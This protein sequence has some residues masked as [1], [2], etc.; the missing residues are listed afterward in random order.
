M[1]VGKRICETLKTIRKQIADA[2]G[3]VYDPKKCNFKGECRGTCPACEQEVKYIE[4]QLNARRMLGKAVTIIGVSTGI[5]A[6]SSCGQKT[7]HNSDMIQGDTCTPVDYEE[8]DKALHQSNCDEGMM[9]TGEAPKNFGSI[10]YDT[11][12]QP[13]SDKKEI[14]KKRVKEN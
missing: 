4:K 14:I 10:E 13:N 12:A 9:K 7:T 11:I 1:N 5:A 6:L 8:F 3:I 2:N